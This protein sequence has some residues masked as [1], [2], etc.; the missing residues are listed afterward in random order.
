M[1]KTFHLT[2]QSR[3]EMV[4][5]TSQIETWIR[6]TGVTNGVAI[7]SSLHTTAGITV[8]ENA[9]PDVKRDMIMRL[10]EVYPWHHENDRHM[11]GNTAAHL[12]T[13]TVGHAQTLI[14]SEGRLVLGT[15]QGVYFCE[16]DR[17]RTN[18][19]FVVKLLTD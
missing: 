18:R 1:M 6:E 3:D 19:K 7:V 2:T 15:W 11:E 8:N 12:K 16:F 14:I 13:S 5:I 9:D 4:D 17:P 10:D